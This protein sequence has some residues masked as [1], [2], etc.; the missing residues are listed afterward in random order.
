M[1][2]L[3]WYGLKFSLSDSEAAPFITHNASFA[4]LGPD[5]REASYESPYGI[6]WF[7]YTGDIK[8]VGPLYF[9]A[10]LRKT[11]S[12]KFS[13]DEMA[14]WKVT[15]NQ[16]PWSFRQ[17]DLDKPEEAQKRVSENIKKLMLRYPH[18]RSV[19][20]FHESYDNDMPSK[21][22]GADPKYNDEIIAKAEKKVA[23]ANMV[24]K[25]YRESF[26]ELKIIAGN[27][28]GSIRITNDLLQFGFDRRYADFIG[29]EAGGQS[30]I[31]ESISEHNTMAAWATREITRIY[32]QEIPLTGCYEFT[33]RRDNLLGP[34][35][36]AE[37][38]VRDILICAAYKFQN[39]SP[40]AL[41]DAGIA[42]YN[43]VWGASGV[44]M[45]YPLL[46]PKP[47]YVAIA[48]AT[49]VLDKA[50]LLQ[51]VPTGSLSVY[52]L[53]FER[54]RQQKDFA[55][56]MWMP[57]GEAELVCE[58]N[59]EPSL[60]LVDLYGKTS[61][62][63]AIGGKVKVPLSG[64]ASYL[65]SP[66][67]A[68][69][70]AVTKRSF[71]AEQ[72]PDNYSPTNRMDKAEEWEQVPDENLSGIFCKRGT[73]TMRDVD[74]PE[75]GRCIELELNKD[76]GSTPCLM[77]EYTAIKLKQAVEVKG[78]PHTIG[79]WV[80]GNSNWGRIFFTIMDAE[81]RLW[82]SSGGYNDWPGD[83]CVNF[84]SWC[85]MRFHIDEKRSPVRN[86]SPG[87]QWKLCNGLMG[88][89]A[90]PGGASTPKYPVKI[91]GIYVTMYRKAVDPVEMRDVS[92]VLRFKDIGAYE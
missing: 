31:P 47:A 88:Y 92:P 42:Y 85:F 76:D 62:L 63:K 18:C 84:D 26:P 44:C 34:Q 36:Q 38:Y 17:E 54:E 46:Y 12:Q 23:L 30:F 21:L 4:V 24:G 25:F 48:T 20:L 53:E 74:D 19:L 87:R 57:R 49:R 35:K 59:G 61:V 72:P 5:T 67:K 64:A 78:E 43:T 32:G 15:L 39:I 3:G 66:V 91:L 9:K 33:C 70:V 68:I 80:K 50:R 89:V 90:R 27:S 8:T 37:Y 75:K 22:A 11:Q 52:A 45:R 82:S 7:D 29:I 55:Y 60:T 79:V 73:F 10:G 51:A 41:Y 69:K 2:D 6:W 56:A 16:I 81:G 77:A 71:K 40:A 86:L 28:G 13:E 58:F 83:L 65:I 1:P 14:P